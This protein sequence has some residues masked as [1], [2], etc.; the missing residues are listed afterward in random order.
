M[1]WEFERM[2][3]FDTKFTDVIRRTPSVK[4]FRLETHGHDVDYQPGQF[5]FI[6]IKINGQ[7]ANHHFTI[8]SSPTEKGYIEF[9]KRITPHEFSQALDVL[10]PG[11]WA[12]IRGPSGSFVL[13]EKP[14]KLGF[15]AGGIGITPIRSIFRYITDKN[16]KWDIV[17]LYGN[18]TFEEIVF[19]DEFEQITRM[20]PE[21]RVEHILSGPEFPSGWKGP[22]GYITKDLIA[23]LIP[24]YQERL[25]YISGPPK[26]VVSLE[27]QILVLNLPREQVKR[28]SFT[29][30]D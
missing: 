23:E 1:V 13:P 26:M 2:W 6:T 25:F 22:K 27:E 8:S 29:G 18:S 14:R 15:L 19:R 5:F 30:Y 11:E 7:D 4:T 3:E 21:V 24:D 28:D 9:T 17:L 10:K 12:H 20:K 16:Q